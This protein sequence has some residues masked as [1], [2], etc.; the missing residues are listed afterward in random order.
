MAKICALGELLVDMTPA[1]LDR[2]QY[3]PGGGPANMACMAVKRGVEAS[4]IS[5]VGNDTF[6]KKLKA[7][8]DSEGVD[9]EALLLSDT[10]PTT[11]AFVHLAE[12][13]ERSFSFYRHGGAD[14]MVAMSNVAKKKIEEA[15]LFYLSSVLL[16]EG[17]SRET[18]FELLDYAKEKEKTIAFD[19]NLR[20]NLWNS[21]DELKA[22]VQKV[23]SYPQLV[24]M[25]EEELAFLSDEEGLIPGIMQ[26]KHT[27]PQI[28]VLIVTQGAEGCTIF[29]EGE[30][31]HVDSYEVKPVDTTGAGDAFMG[32]FLAEMLKMDRDPYNLMLDEASAAAAVACA[33]GGLTTTSM[34]GIDAQP[35][36]TAVKALM[37][38]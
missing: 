24:K 32:A 4:F 19:P 27:Y 13:G 23:L 36:M 18:S 37:D 21:D 11:L 10:Y 8:M 38:K 33:C 20:F 22:M 28:E 14:T 26:L 5:Q 25:S 6:G 17:T 7:K 35:D 12:D 9:T 31:A 3:N 2:Y 34:G 30:M 29:I 15:D 16:S 1:G